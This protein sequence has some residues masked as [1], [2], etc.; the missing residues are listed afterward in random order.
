MSAEKFWLKPHS[1]ISNPLGIFAIPEGSSDYYAK[2]SLVIY[3][4]TSLNIYLTYD[5]SV[6][7]IVPP[8]TDSEYKAS[9]IDKKY[10]NIAKS[11]NIIAYVEDSTKER[12]IQGDKKITTCGFYERKDAKIIG[13]CLANN[14]R[15]GFD[16]YDVNHKILASFFRA[17]NTWKIEVYVNKSNN[18][19]KSVALMLAGLRI[20]R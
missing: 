16:L 9:V 10:I 6:S 13:Y 19:N 14:T 18:I 12:V 7:D 4:N 8:F 1:S 5:F 20:W 2:T 15:I 3:E 11:N 17:A